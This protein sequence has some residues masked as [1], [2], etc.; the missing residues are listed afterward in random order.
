MQQQIVNLMF[1][2]CAATSLFATTEISVINSFTR[3]ENTIPSWTA[4][5]DALVKDRLQ[6]MISPVELNFDSHAREYVQAHTTYGYKGTEKMLGNFTLYF[7]IFEQYLREYNL[8]QQLKYLPMIESKL[9]PHA[10]SGAGAVGLWQFM[11]E[12]GK[13][14]G[15][16]IGTY[17]DERKDPNKSTEAAVRHL[18]RMH[19]NFGNWEL[20]IAA[21]NCGAGNVRK[22]IRLSGSKEYR[23]LKKFLPRETQHYLP[24]FVAASYIAENFHFHGLRPRMPEQDLSMTSTVKLYSSITF[25]KIASL[26][27]VALADVQKLNP[28]YNRGVI[29]ATKK[30]H[31]LILPEIGMTRLQSH[32]KYSNIRTNNPELNTA[33]SGGQVLQ[34]VTYRVKSGDTLGA[35]A[36]TFNCDLSEILAWND[37]STSR[38][39]LRQELV[40]Y[41]K[42]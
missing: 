15:L 13:E 20:A 14:L 19:D 36:N 32:L 26:S 10:I 42:Q 38:I 3:L 18:K 35:L 31:Y 6:M 40:F 23:K 39:N 21:Y 9:N 8:P 5:D 28:A 27:G 41:M 4:K 29:P 2:L 30:G 24:R 22:A 25:R 11:P 17:T 37:L 16:T 7:P 12:T 34:K 1:L 33:S